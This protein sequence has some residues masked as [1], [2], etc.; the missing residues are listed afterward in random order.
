MKE[1]PRAASSRYGAGLELVKGQASPTR[2][3]HV[4]PVYTTYYVGSNMER[5]MPI[6]Y[7][8]KV[9]LVN[10]SVVAHVLRLQK[11]QGSND[12]GFLC[13]NECHQLE[14]LLISVRP[15]RRQ[16]LIITRLVAECKQPPAC[17]P[18]PHLQTTTTKAPPV[19]SSSGNASNYDAAVESI[20]FSRF[21]EIIA[22]FVLF[23][24]RN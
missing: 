1:R 24:N 15:Q 12:R 20:S 22:L 18:R 4:N 14:T 13:F 17:I 2:G 6:A 16:Y 5:S 7:C 9:R 19:D 10:P 8:P 21:C 23:R 3:M 11:E